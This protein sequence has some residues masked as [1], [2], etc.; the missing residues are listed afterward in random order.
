MQCEQ[1]FGPMKYNSSKSVKEEVV[2]GRWT[3]K[4][5]IECQSGHSI[6]R[7]LGVIVNVE[8]ECELEAAIIRHPSNR[9]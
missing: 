7:R 6:T 9:D 4:A 1:C 3:I 2:E 5:H 8:P